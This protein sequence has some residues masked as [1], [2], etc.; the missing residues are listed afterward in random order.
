MWDNVSWQLQQFNF[1]QRDICVKHG[2]GKTPA[3]TQQ[4]HLEQLRTRDFLTA[5]L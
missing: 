1:L 4:I 5:E 3:R 2:H